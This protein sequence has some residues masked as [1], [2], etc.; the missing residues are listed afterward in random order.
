MNQFLSLYASLFFLNSVI[1]FAKFLITIPGLFLLCISLLIIA[2][3]R[4][5]LDKIK[6]LHAHWH[7]MFETIQFSSQEFYDHVTER[8]REKGI[9]EVEISHVTHHEHGMFSAK[10][11]YLRVKFKE[12]IVDICA[13]PFGKESFFV[14]WWQ[15][16]AV[17][18]I[19]DLLR[20]IPYI[21]FLFSKREKTFYEQDTEIMFKETV[22][23]C[24]KDAIENL[25]DVKGERL[26][27]IDWTPWTRQYSKA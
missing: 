1:D 25:T 21:G 20:E 7:H 8:V 18:T 4:Y 24:V 6:V 12:Y 2:A 26:F 22:I 15:G 17:S 23:L 19:R 14:S 5:H 3:F 11:L 13:A 27:A 9:P 16:E 10:R